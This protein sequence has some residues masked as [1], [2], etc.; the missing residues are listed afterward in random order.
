[1][2][3]QI[4]RYLLPW[5]ALCLV[6]TTG[7]SQTITTSVNKKRILIGEQFIYNIS[8]TI[9]AGT[10]V[11]FYSIPDSMEGFEIVGRDKIDTTGTFNVKTL[12]QKI[13]FTSFDSGRYTI[14]SFS[15]GENLNTDSFQIDVG[16][17]K[18]DSSGIPR[19]IKPILD[20]PAGKIKWYYFVIALA[21]LALLIFLVYRNLKNRRNKQPLI[22]QTLL[23]PFEEA[24]RSLEKL[25]LQNIPGDIPVKDFHVQLSKIFR[26][27]FS[28]KFYPDAKSKTTSDL[29]ILVSGQQVSPLTISKLASALRCNDAVLFAKYLPPSLESHDCLGRMKEIIQD[30]ENHQNNIKIAV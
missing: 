26:N 28:R 18:A 23:P 21:L 5:Q 15:I 19:D 9:P 24:M 22:T 8:V 4:S 12:R 11:N 1:M 25:Q 10:P 16:Y 3:Q 14:P 20:A 13:L 27:Y 30:L 2:N 29:L 6:F 17:A 7:T